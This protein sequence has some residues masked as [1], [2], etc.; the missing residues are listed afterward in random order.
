MEI[1]NINIWT[2]DNYTFNSNYFKKIK[3]Q[4]YKIFESFFINFE[5]GTLFAGYF[6]NMIEN[7][8]F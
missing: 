6:K 3:K 5:T 2:L 1:Q 4:K 7:C 8:K